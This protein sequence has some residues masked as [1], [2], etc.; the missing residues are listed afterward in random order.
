M[1]N[2][3]CE[4]YIFLLLCYHFKINRTNL[5]EME[6]ITKNLKKK[7]NI[8]NDKCLVDP[9]KS[10]RDNFT[11]PMGAE[12]SSM[13][14]NKL[15]QHDTINR[16]LLD[17]TV[18]S[19]VNLLMNNP[20]MLVSKSGDVDASSHSQHTNLHEHPTSKR[21]QCTND[22][23][24]TDYHPLD[25]HNFS[26]PHFTTSNPNFHEPVVSG[27]HDAAT[28][29]SMQRDSDR[30]YM[31]EME[32]N[33][34]KSKVSGNLMQNTSEKSVMSH[35]DNTIKSVSNDINLSLKPPIPPKHLPNNDIDGN[36][37]NGDFLSSKTLYNEAEDRNMQVSE[38][39]NVGSFQNKLDDARENKQNGDKNIFNKDFEDISDI[40]SVNNDLHDRHNEADYT[41]DDDIVQLLNHKNTSSSSSSPFTV[42]SSDFKNDDDFK[43]LTV[44]VKHK[45]HNLNNHATIQDTRKRN[46]RKGRNVLL[47]SLPVLTVQ[48]SQRVARIL[49]QNMP[50]I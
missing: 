18:T 43:V 34:T 1:R 25:S 36:V 26:N 5:E 49:T 13:N 45:P 12:K 9:P 44:Q 32:A 38:S 46:V 11:S 14:D 15:Q 7:I 33:E 30:S 23:T 24:Q 27:G 42:I 4:N 8:I 10:H 47:N 40:S 35:P 21:F 41:S 50:Q 2:E 17:D 16:T 37:Y 31:A 6:R 20:E 28:D 39:N 22:H 19:F 48:Q 3:R 29:D